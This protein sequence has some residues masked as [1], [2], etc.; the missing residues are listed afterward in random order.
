VLAAV[1][2]VAVLVPPIATQARRYEW[3]EALQYV[4]LGLVAPGFFV[5][6]APWER[7]GLARPARSLAAARRRHPERLRSAVLVGL[8]LCCMA[9]WRV[10]A[11][12]DRLP[13]SRWWL[14]LEAVTLTCSGTVLWLECVSSAPLIPRSTRPFRIALC[15]VSMWTT[16]VIAY[17]VAMSTADW[18]PAYRHQVGRGLS[19]VADQQLAAGLLWAAATACFVPVIFSNLLWWLHSEED[20]DEALNRMVSEERRRSGSRPS[21]L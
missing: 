20:P 5:A 9:A 12:V 13:S 19:K 4:V 14:A 8:A 7:L 11:I 6:G 21:R 10:P 2:V 16:W 15:A 18:Y 1:L 3:V 17:M